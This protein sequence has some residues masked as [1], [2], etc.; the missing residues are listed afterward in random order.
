MSSP[1]ALGAEIEAYQVLLEAHRARPHNDD[2]YED[3]LK[4][5]AAMERAWLHS[6]A[7]VPSREA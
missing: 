4:A 3:L 1:T 5:R 6:L 2:L 7:A